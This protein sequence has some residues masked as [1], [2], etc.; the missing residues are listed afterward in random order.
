MGV[1]GEP[2]DLR[3]FADFAAKKWPLRGSRQPSAM[4]YQ[5]RTAIARV[6]GM[7]VLLH[8]YGRRTQ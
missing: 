1:A 4:S 8:R 6:G 7:A 5:P 3:F 2:N